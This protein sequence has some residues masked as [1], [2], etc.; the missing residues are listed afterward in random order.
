MFSQLFSHQDLSQRYF[1]WKPLSTRH[2]FCLDWHCCLAIFIVATQ[3]TISKSVASVELTWTFYYYD[4][5]VTKLREHWDE[6]NSKVMQRK[7]QLDAMLGDSQRYEAKRN[8]VEN[9]LDRMETRLGRMRSV[10]HTADVLEA[11]LREQKVNSLSFSLSLSLSLSLY[12]FFLYCLLYYSTYICLSF[13]LFYLHDISYS[14]KIVSIFH[15]I[16][17]FRHNLNSLV[18][19]SIPVLPCGTS[20]IQASDRIVQSTDPE[21][22]SGIS[23]RWYDSRQEDDWNDQSA[24]QQ[25]QHKVRRYT[26]SAFTQI[27]ITCATL[28][29][30]IKKKTH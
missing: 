21:A 28:I 29:C 26:H 3:A 20:S 5:A 22:H 19:L 25:S 7:T 24:L 23:T 27:Q 9:W 16:S 6:T 18:R 11:Q 2:L 15:F 14:S 12:L 30:K 17:W 13:I 10:G 8:E 4:I 1:E